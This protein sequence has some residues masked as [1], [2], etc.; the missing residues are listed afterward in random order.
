MK[1]IK[2]VAFIFFVALFFAG[3]TAGVNQ[4]LLRRINLNE[5]TRSTKYL[6]D[7]MEIEIPKDAGPQEITRLADKRI[8]KAEVDGRT[9]FR[10]VDENGSPKGY[11]FRISGKG[12]W[13][14]IYGLIS[15]NPDLNTIKDIVFTSHN[16]TPGLGARI[17]EPWFREQFRGL[18]LANKIDEDTY[19]EIVQGGAEKK[20][21]IDSI[22][23][24]TMTSTALEK[25][26]N[27][28]LARIEKL[29]DEVRRITWPSPPKK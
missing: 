11:A 23:G 26:L 22:T 1:S 17:E 12:F 4:A 6:L 19:L 16:E 21:R 7:V 8:R 15:F 10:A 28:D 13:G 3:L 14:M 9:V 20:N 25:I 2:E 27:E 18:K 24:A 5:Q 29:K